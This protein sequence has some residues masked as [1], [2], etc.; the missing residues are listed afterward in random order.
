MVNVKRRS[1][2]FAAIFNTFQP[3]LDEL[4]NNTSDKF[5]IIIGSSFFNHD[6]VFGTYLNHSNSH[7]EDEEISVYF[8]LLWD[9]ENL[10]IRS[11]VKDL[12]FKD[13]DSLGDDNNRNDLYEGEYA[14]T[15]YSTGYICD[16]VFPWDYLG[17][18]P[19]EGKKI[20]FDVYA[21]CQPLSRTQDEQDYKVKLHYTHMLDEGLDPSLMAVLN[22][23]K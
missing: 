17:F 4:I 13:T 5:D 9:D 1:E 11:I 6:N 14:I 18:Q 16:I 15:T 8:N 7:C 21:F 19:Q 12:N 23:C 10:Y 2:N 20:F 22:L 3:S